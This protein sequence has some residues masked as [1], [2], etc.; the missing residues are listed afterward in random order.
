MNLAIHTNAFRDMSFDEACRIIN[1]TWPEIYIEAS[2]C[3]EHLY[4]DLLDWSNVRKVSKSP[5]EK[6]GIISGGWCDFVIGDGLEHGGILE[7]QLNLSSAWNV[8]L[9]LFLA[10]PNNEPQASPQNV[11]QSITSMYTYFR[12]WG[13]DRTKICFENHGGIT[14]DPICLDGIISTIRRV[15]QS[16]MIGITLDPANYAVCGQDAV[17]STKALTPEYIYHVHA[18]DID[19]NGDFCAVGDGILRD[20]W[21][22][23]I[24]YLKVIGYNGLITIE[25]EGNDLDNRIV[26]ISNSLN[27]LKE[28]LDA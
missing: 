20:S 10:H 12:K 24:H 4:K 9:R 15:L 13:I 7:R 8:S 25:Y 2:T 23:I 1:N 16:E 14:A 11:I 28:I 26:H 3:R 22:E 5:P 6:V 18:K 19:S 21:V 17:V 27:F